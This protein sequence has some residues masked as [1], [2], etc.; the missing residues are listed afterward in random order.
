MIACPK[1]SLWRALCEAIERPHWAADP[2]FATFADRGRNRGELTRELDLVLRRRSAA[3][4][5]EVMAAARVP[6][7]PI[8]DIAAALREPQ[9]V[10]RDAVGSCPHP[11]LGEVRQVRTPFRLP[12][13]D[14]EI[15]PAPALGEDNEAPVGD[16]SRRRFCITIPET[17]VRAG[18]WDGKEQSRDRSRARAAAR[19]VPIDVRDT[20]LRAR[21]RRPLRPQPGARLDPSLPGAGGG[22]GRR[23]PSP[24][25]GRLDACTYRGHGAVLAMG[26]PA[27]RAFGEILGRGNGLCGGKGGSMHLTDVGVGAIGSFAIVGGHLPIACGTA[28]AASYRSSDAV[29]LCFFGDGAVNIGAFHE[30]LNLAA[31]W[32]LPVVFVCENNLYGEYS[33]L[34]ATTPIERLADRADAYGMRKAAHRR[35]RRRRDAR[36]DRRRGRRGSGR[37]GTDPDRGAHLPPQGPL[38]LRPGRLPAGRRARALAR[39]RPPARHRQRPRSRRRRSR[40]ARADRRAEADREMAAALERALAWDAARPR[41][42]ARPRLGRDDRGGA[43]STATVTYREAIQRALTDAMEADADVFLLGEDVGAAGGAFKLTEGLFERFGPERVRDTPI[44]EQA[45]VGVAIGAADRRSASGR[46]D[47]VLRLRRGLLRRARQRAAEVPLHDRRPGHRSGD[48]PDVQRRRR[49]RRPALAAGRELVPQRGR[50][51]DRAP[52]DARE[53]VRAAAR[54]RSRTPT[55][56]SSSST[57]ASSS[58]R[59]SSRRTRRRC[60]WGPQSSSVAAST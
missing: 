29:S 21:G 22:F 13:V 33:P 59:E 56:C 32:K 58:R 43:R 14:R 11:R 17:F 9:A 54:R 10:V 1:E 51:E 3:E 52:L 8:N 37:R 60:D 30:A 20:S 27:D 34:A 49:L 57:A 24:A 39:A 26:A 41:D 42:P 31:I 2:R 18:F 38:S 44:S 15:R 4:W 36:G 48:D 40:A 16:G 12:G 35:Q 23:L 55:R 50:A 25:E 46:G 7:A 6:C 47:H 53:H 5:L 28:F 45:I 19:L